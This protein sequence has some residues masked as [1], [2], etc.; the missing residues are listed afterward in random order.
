MSSGYSV[1]CAVAVPIASVAIDAIATVAVR[2]LI[3]TLMLE[4][5][6]NG[7]RVMIVHI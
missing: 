6:V 1:R 2:T 3:F 5:M 7:S 4:M